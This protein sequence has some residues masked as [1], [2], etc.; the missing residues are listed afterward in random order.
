MSKWW[1]TAFQRRISSRFGLW[2][3]A[4]QAR[5]ALFRTCND[6]CLSLSDSFNCF[7]TADVFAALVRASIWLRNVVRYK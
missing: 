1:V 7:H 2:T 5:A 3:L 4:P 6:F